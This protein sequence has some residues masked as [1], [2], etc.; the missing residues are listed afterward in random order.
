MIVLIPSA[1]GL[2][3]KKATKLAATS[4]TVHHTD[5]EA[6]DEPPSD[7][8]TLYLEF[9]SFDTMHVVA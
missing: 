4:R 6:H 9:G 8:P 2:R 5:T 3:E 1:K 7:I